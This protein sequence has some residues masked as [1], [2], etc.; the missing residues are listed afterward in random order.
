MVKIIYPDGVVQKEDAREILEFVMEMRARV[1][2]QL[3]RIKP[4]DEFMGTRFIYIDNDTQE[5][6][7]ILVPECVGLESRQGSE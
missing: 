4:D 3:K 5:E 1:K 6:K 2:E 7:E